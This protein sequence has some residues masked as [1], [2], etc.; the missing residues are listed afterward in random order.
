MMTT[1][2]TAANRAKAKAAHTHSHTHRNIKSDYCMPTLS[3]GQTCMSVC[4]WQKNCQKIRPC[5]VAVSFCEC[6]ASCE[7]FL[8]RKQKDAVGSGAHWHTHTYSQT[9]TGTY[10]AT[11][12]KDKLSA[13]KTGDW[14]EL[15]IG[16]AETERS[17]A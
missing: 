3:Q 6:R 9:H 1:T 15:R 5:F 14:G 13:W 8:K 4:V 7:S 12:C 10:V 2:E 16:E 17:S 11:G